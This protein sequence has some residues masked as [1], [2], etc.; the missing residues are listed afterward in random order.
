MTLDTA[1]ALELLNLPP[2]AD[3]TAIEQACAQKTAQIKGQLEQ[4]QT[5]LLAGS[6]RSYQGL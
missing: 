3:A 1:Q 2:E 6:Q 5:L 4:A